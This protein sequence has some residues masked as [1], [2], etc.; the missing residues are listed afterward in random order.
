MRIPRGEIYNNE[1]FFHIES[2]INPG[3]S[4]WTLTEAKTFEKWLK[5]LIV[6]SDLGLVFWMI[7]P[8]GI[9]LIVRKESDRAYTLEDKLSALRGLGEVKFAERWEAQSFEGSKELSHQHSEKRKFVNSLSQDLGLFTKSLKQRI[10]RAYNSKNKSVGSLWRERA[11]VFYLPDSPAVLSEVAAFIL[12]QAEAENG[13]DCLDWPGTVA[14][15]RGGSEDAEDG[16]Q[17]IFQNSSAASDQLDRLLRSRLEVL[18][19]I[20]T[21]LRLSTPGRRPAW[22][23]AGERS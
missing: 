17:Q 19:K 14:E 9:G 16:L 22:R 5:E 21:V 10:S 18:E 12:A 8:R 13:K 3:L 4:P 15:I 11:K 20:P 1:G 23:P 2:L 7:H 6:L